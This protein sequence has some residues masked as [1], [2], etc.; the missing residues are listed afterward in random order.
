MHQ[1]RARFVSTGAFL[2]LSA[3]G[4]LGCSAAP[5]PAPTPAAAA[6]AQSS[7]EIKKEILAQDDRRF[8]AMVQAD[9]KTMGEILH[10]DLTY[11]HSSGQLANREQTIA[12]VTTGQI[13]YQNILP[14]E[15]EVRLYG[16]FA[17]VTGRAQLRVYSE[18]SKLLG[19]WVRFTE[20]WTRNK[21]VWQLIAWQSTRPPE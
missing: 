16:D 1:R 13:R 6:P 5:K 20:V 17:V 12:Q 19:F 9:A 14:S 15:R 8:A 3:L 2:T 4:L 7:E 11:I 21:G 10:D 18:G